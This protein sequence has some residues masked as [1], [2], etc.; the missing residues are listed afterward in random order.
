MRDA[1]VLRLCRLHVRLLACCL[2]IQPM[3]NVRRAAL[4][5]RGRTMYIYCNRKTSRFSSFARS[6][7]LTRSHSYMFCMCMC[8]RTRL[9][10][11]FFLSLTFL[12]FISNII[13][14]IVIIV[15]ITGVLN[16]RVEVYIAIVSFACIPFSFI[17][18]SRLH[19]L[20]VHHT[21]LLFRLLPPSLLTEN[22][23]HSLASLDVFVSF[24]II[25]FSIIS[26]ISSCVYVCE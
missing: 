12:F 18:F 16:Q 3:S 21:S 25:R 17:Y 10:V 13:I 7:F 23:S 11:P 2:L 1:T 15:I 26:S 8:A 4:S 6:Q 5:R 19:C 24:G 20:H 22:F 9:C 14:S